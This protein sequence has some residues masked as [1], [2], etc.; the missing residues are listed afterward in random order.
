MEPGKAH[1][2]S[3]NQRRKAERYGKKPTDLLRPENMKPLNADSGSMQF[4]Q[5]L[6]KPKKEE[7]H[8]LDELEFERRRRDVLP[9][10]FEKGKRR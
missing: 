8:S 1:K 3:K 6:L 7:D 2:L 9:G 10:D 4:I 5:S